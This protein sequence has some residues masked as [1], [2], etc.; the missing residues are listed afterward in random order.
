MRCVMCIEKVGKAQRL[1]PLSPLSS[2]ASRFVSRP[3][4][5]SMFMSTSTPSTSV[6][7]FLLLLSSNWLTNAALPNINDFLAQGDR[8]LSADRLEEAINHYSRGIQLLP[9]QWSTQEEED[10]NDQDYQVSAEETEQIMS[11]HTNYATALSFLEG[12]TLNVIN[13]YRTSCIC[14]RKWK[15]HSNNKVNDMKPKRVA[16]QSFFFLGMTYQD[17]ATSDVGTD[18]QQI[19]YLQQA[20]KA[21]A[22][23]TKL[24]PNHWSSY[25]N[26]GVVLAD[27]GLDGDGNT[28]VSLQLFEEG[29]LSY[30]KAIELLSNGKSG[31]SKA[32]D[33]PENVEEVVAE[34]NYRIGLCLVPF[35][36]MTPSSDGDEDYNTKLCTLPGVAADRSCFELAAYQFHTAMQYGPHEG[37]LNALTLVTADAT[38]GMSTD[39]GKV[40][41]LFE[42]WAGEPPS[43]VLPL[44][45]SGSA[46][47]YYRLQSATRSA[48]GA[49]NPDLRENTAFVRFSQHF[50]QKG[51]PVPEI[52]AENLEQHIYLQED[53]GFTTLYSYLLKKD[54]YFP[55]YLIRIYKRTVE[56][57]ARLQIMGSEG[58]D[59]SLC[60]PRAD[61][62]RQSMQWDLN[63]FKYLEESKD[64]HKQDLLIQQKTSICMA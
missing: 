7:V 41:Q 37:A 50:H 60:Y 40:Q 6:I 30:Q 26:M 4:S 23:A 53:L 9:K 29:I 11:L 51:L 55:D 1:P 10:V 43:L 45:P 54:D 16:V 31:S 58:L 62:D 34:L 57:L 63:Y 5:S 22:A 27:V 8:A 12:S 38:F 21:Y 56:Q 20:V 49:Y 61:F 3:L 47:I 14:Y 59:Y 33:P 18:T 52:F 25:A 17:I 24:D 19:E 48:I 64:P 13:A 32:T 15:K 28:A 35:L 42:D 36:F 2:S 46:R 39:V 44:A